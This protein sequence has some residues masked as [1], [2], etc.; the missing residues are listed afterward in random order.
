[1]NHASGLTHQIKFFC[2]NLL[3]N[4]FAASAGAA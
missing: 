3:T 4:C 1:V 2:F